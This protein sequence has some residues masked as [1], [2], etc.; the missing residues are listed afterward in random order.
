MKSCKLKYFLSRLN[1]LKVYFSPFKFF[2]PKLYMG[3][4]AIGTP[5]FYPRRMVPCPDKPGHNMFVDKKIGFDFVSL[6][7]KTKYEDYRHEWDPIW[8]FVIFGFQIALIFHP[9]HNMHYWEC[10]LY[11]TKDTDKSKST[12]E[13]IKEAREKNPCVWTVGRTGEEK[14]ICYWDE[15]LK[16]KY[17]KK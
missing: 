12:K 17:L 11:Y 8:S 6:G 10:W 13:R 1:F 7:W 16:S 3:K 2:L 15:V 9:P 5:Y 4:I 14:E